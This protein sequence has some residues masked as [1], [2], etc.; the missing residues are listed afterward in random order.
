MVRIKIKT[1]GMHCTSCEMLIKDALEE[2]EGVSKAEAAH[3]TGIVSV[4]FNEKKVKKSDL[5]KIIKLEG[6][7]VEV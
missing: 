4:E 6:Y 3:K 1:N 5:I 2:V 7:Q